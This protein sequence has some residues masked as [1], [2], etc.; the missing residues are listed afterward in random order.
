MYLANFFGCIMYADDLLLLSASVTGLQ[1]MLHICHSFAQFS[2]IVSNHKK[3]VCFKV[4]PLWC[5]SASAM[6][7]GNKDLQWVTSFKYLG[8][9]FLSGLAVKI[10]TCH[11]KRTFYKACNGILSHC[12][13]ADVFVKLSLVKAYCLPVLTYCI[14]ALNLPVVKIKDLGVCW[15]DCFRKLFGYKR[16]ESVKEMQYFC[17][18]L[19]FDLIYELQR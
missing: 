12:S 19:S 8:I 9:N 5:R 3:S 11:T 1:Q 4:G 2:D 7:L 13:T 16:F 6:L 17:G 18:E 14:D 15:N 10:G